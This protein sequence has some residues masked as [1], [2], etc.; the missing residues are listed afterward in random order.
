MNPWCCRNFT[1]KTYQMWTE[2]LVSKLHKRFQKI[3]VEGTLPNSGASIALIPKP[4]KDLTG[5]GKQILIPL[6]NTDTKIFNQSASNHVAFVCPGCCDRIPQTERLKQQACISHSSG[7]W[8]VQDQ[9]ASRLGVCGGPLP[10]SQEV[11]FLLCPQV[12][13][14]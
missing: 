13:K 8:E 4:D 5:K 6:T 11:G 7:G 1:G 10:G 2:E 9:S 14:G 12:M 3:E